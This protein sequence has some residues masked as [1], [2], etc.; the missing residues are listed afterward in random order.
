M[1]L[2]HRIEPIVRGPA[3]LLEGIPPAALTGGTLLAALASLVAI[4]AALTNQPPTTTGVF[5]LA[6]PL[7]LG[8]E[9]LVHELAHATMCHA[10]GVR[11]REAGIR[12][13]CF[14][15]PIAYVDRTDAYRVRSR[16][17]RAAIALAG[18]VVD[19]TAAGVAAAASLVLPGRAGATAFLILAVLIV[20]LVGNLN[21]LLPTDGYHA[22]EAAS[23]EL[24]FRS[25]AFTYV[26]HRLLLIA[27]PSALAATSRGRRAVYTGYAILGGLCTVSLVAMVL[28]MART[29]MPSVGGL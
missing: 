9:V 13:W 2:L 4:V 20:L 25:R 17:C 23:G 22:I 3:W 11:V 6:V 5:W 24:N 28:M 27:M 12:L 10:L 18:P 19:L 21:P 14:L 29:M 26:G 16:A 7:L 15:F 1:P 8:L